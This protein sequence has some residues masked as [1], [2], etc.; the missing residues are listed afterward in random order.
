MYVS[1]EGL[2]TPTRGLCTYVV[3]VP[4]NRKIGRIYD[5]EAKMGI[6]SRFNC[7]FVGT[8]GLSTVKP[9]LN[10]FCIE[11][12]EFDFSF[13]QKIALILYFRLKFL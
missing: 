13:V 5:S 11:V 12:N 4:R 9:E 3:Y 6:H 7:I 2:N 8:S 10:V 1:V